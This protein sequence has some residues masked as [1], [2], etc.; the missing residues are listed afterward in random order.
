VG[1]SVGACACEGGV[2]FFFPGSLQ[3]DVPMTT[4]ISTNEAKIRREFISVFVILPANFR[5]SPWLRI[6][7]YDAKALLRITNGGQ[8]QMKGSTFS[9]A[10]F[11]F[12]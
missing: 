1:E 2:A 11:E 12:H 5:N 7:S 6:S 10:G 8:S 3:P 4:V 9:I